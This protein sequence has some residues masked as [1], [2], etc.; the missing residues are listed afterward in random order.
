MAMQSAWLLSQILVAHQKDIMAGKGKNEAGAEYT[1]QWHQ[2]FASRIH[3]AAVFARLAM[4][5]SW[6][7]S[8]IGPVVKQFPSILTIGAKLSGKNKQ[9][10]CQSTN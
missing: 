10:V 3:A 9:V 5:P 8:L 1:K 4:M 6:S 2:H 7:V